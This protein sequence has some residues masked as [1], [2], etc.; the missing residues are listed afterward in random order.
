MR[1]LP[2]RTV[3]GEV[4]DYHLDFPE[5]ADRLVALPIGAEIDLGGTAMRICQSVIRDMPSTVWGFD[6]A[7]RVLF[8]GDGFAYAHYHE[9]G[10]CGQTAEEAPTCR[11][12][13]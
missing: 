3:V 10:H 8:P 7:R 6:T 4:R 12:P 11:S 2:G 1:A 5:Y 9:A 13:R